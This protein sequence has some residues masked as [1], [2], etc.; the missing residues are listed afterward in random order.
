MY[1]S[2]GSIGRG[3]KLYNKDGTHRNGVHI[4][5]GHNTKVLI[6]YAEVLEHAW[7]SGYDKHNAWGGWHEYGTECVERGATKQPLIKK[8]KEWPMV[9]H[10]VSLF[11]PTIHYQGQVFVNN[12]CIYGPLKVSWTRKHLAPLAVSQMTSFLHLPSFC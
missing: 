10:S 1:E 9:L 2:K 5:V 3:S 12:R 4:L 7:I 11:L 8:N 6:G